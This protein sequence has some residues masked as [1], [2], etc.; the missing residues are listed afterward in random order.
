MRKAY[1][2]TKNVETNLA[3][4]VAIQMAIEGI[5]TDTEPGA[6]RIIIG[7]ILSSDASLPTDQKFCDWIVRKISL[8]PDKSANMI[9]G[10]LTKGIG[11]NIIEKA[12]QM[13]GLKF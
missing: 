2:P 6:N 12:K 4:S 5:R 11:N 3:Y 8:L 1:F 7:G 9:V 13:L 10:A